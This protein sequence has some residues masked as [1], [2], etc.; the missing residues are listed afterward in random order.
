MFEELLRIV[1]IFLRWIDLDELALVAS[2]IKV[3][4]DTP[5]MSK[6]ELVVLL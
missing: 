3:E 4:I 1:L 6:Y 5:I 2:L